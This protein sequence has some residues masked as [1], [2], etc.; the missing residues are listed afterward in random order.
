MPG[1]AN[2]HSDEQL[3]QLNQLCNDFEAACKCEPV[4][5]AEAWVRQL[6]EALQDAASRELLLLEIAYRQ[7]AGDAPSVEELFKRFP[8]LPRLWLEE[9]CSG[10]AATPDDVPE[11]LGDYRVLARIGGG[12]MGTV[13]KA[14]H[15]RMGR[16]VA[17]KVLRREIQR[18]PALLRRFDREVR[19]AARLTH[20][21][22]VAALDAREQNGQHFLITEY[23]EGSDLEQWVRRHGP[24]APDEAV[25]CIVQVARGLDYAHR[26]G[27]VHRDIKPANLLRDEQGNIKILDMGLARL[28]AGDDTATPDL[29][30]SGVVMGTAAYMAPEQA[31]DTRRADARSDLY[32]LGCTLFFLI[33]GRPVFV[34]ETAVDTILSHVTEPIPSLSQFNPSIPAELDAVFRRLIAKRP[35]DR[36]QSAAELLQALQ[37]ICGQG[38]ETSA[39]PPPMPEFY[40]TSTEVSIPPT[41]IAPPIAIAPPPPDATDGQ[42]QQAPVHASVSRRKLLL[43]AVGA[44]A[45]AIVGGLATRNWWRGDAPQP[46]PQP[47]HQGGLEFNGGTSYVAVRDLNPESGA[48]YTIEAIVRTPAELLGRPSNLVS[49]LGPDW[50]ALY[51]DGDGRWGVARYWKA[52]SILRRTVARAEPNTRVHLAALFQEGNLKLYVNGRDVADETSV[53]P[54]SATSGGLFIGGADLNNLPDPRFFLGVIEGIQIS[55]GARYAAP[56]PVPPQLEAD[57]RTLALF[58]LDEGTGTQTKS[59]DGRWTG[60]IVDATWLPSDR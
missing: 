6:P 8:E 33:A 57:A 42:A 35:D 13:F 20:P 59:A 14:E 34:A 5:R 26:H 9:A 24:L 47:E 28:D 38:L 44:G 50:M 21:N 22:I 56:F 39:Q 45:L 18:D 49:W 17:L 4:P 1:D 31:R 32:S 16:V 19:A 52:Q 40:G 51:L 3:L 2:S 27:V 12:G 30:K 10:G 55:R 53:F 15:E 11:Q 48:S 58:P 46:L 29:T 7:R 37:S 43:G 25:A 41:V 54:L 60:Q 36:F 23:V